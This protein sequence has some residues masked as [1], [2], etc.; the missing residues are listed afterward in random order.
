L[1]TSAAAAAVVVLAV[2]YWYSDRH[3]RRSSVVMQTILDQSYDHLVAMIYLQ[4]LMQPSGHCR[5]EQ[6]TDVLQ[7]HAAA[8]AAVRK[9]SAFYA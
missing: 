9:L 8:A 4:R 2:D 5:A 3:R 1:P 6:K 7:L